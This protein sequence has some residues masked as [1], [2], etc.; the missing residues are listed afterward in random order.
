[1]PWPR[2]TVSTY[3]QY[4]VIACCMAKRILVKT[5]YNQGKT[6]KI[7]A[8]VICCFVFLMQIGLLVNTWVL[9]VSKISRSIKNMI[10]SR[11][12]SEEEEKW[13]EIACKFKSPGI[14][15]RTLG[16]QTSSKSREHIC[17]TWF[18]WKVLKRSEGREDQNMELKIIMLSEMSHDFSLVRDKGTKTGN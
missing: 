11:W 12:I 17:H 4:T 14:I 6:L 1:M 7:E 5:G 15:T 13:L 2:Y 16:K 8:S 18:N 10:L 3:A 9:S